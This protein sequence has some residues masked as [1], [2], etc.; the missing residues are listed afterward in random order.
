MQIVTQNLKEITTL[1]DLLPA[2]PNCSHK[3]P[4]ILLCH[5]E[6]NDV[7]DMITCTVSIKI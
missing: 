3:C 7:T 2:T 1:A 4:Q 5:V 6:S